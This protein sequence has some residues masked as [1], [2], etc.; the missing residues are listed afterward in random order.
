[1]GFYSIPFFS[2]HSIHVLCT[3]ILYIYRQNFFLVRN[4]HAFYKYKICG[5]IGINLAIRIFLS[6]YNILFNQPTAV[7]LYN[8]SVCL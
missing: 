6:I 2:T 7:I 1:M 3:F 8:N 5:L 4:I